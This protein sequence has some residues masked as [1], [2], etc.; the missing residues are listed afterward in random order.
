MKTTLVTF[1]FILLVGCSENDSIALVMEASFTEQFSY[2]C[3]EHA[4][5]IE[6][7]ELYM[8]VCFNKELAI[9]AIEANKV[10]QVQINTKHILEMQECLSKESGKDYWKETNMPEFILNQTN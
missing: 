3:E 9:A 6:A 8:G 2:A 10:E 7:T 5:C 4:K 1:A